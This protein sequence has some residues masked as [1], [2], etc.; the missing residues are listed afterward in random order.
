MINEQFLLYLL[1]FCFFDL[2]S[3]YPIVD[4]ETQLNGATNKEK[5][6]QHDP[7]LEQERQEH[8]IAV[9]NM[10]PRPAG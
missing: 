6:K 2:L 10:L 7:N 4:L 8:E 5:Y 1:V 3:P 9:S